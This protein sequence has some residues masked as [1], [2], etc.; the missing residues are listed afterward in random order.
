MLNPDR[1]GEKAAS[2]RTVVSAYIVFRLVD[3]KTSAKTN[4]EEEE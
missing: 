1:I 2:N 4:Q 3:A